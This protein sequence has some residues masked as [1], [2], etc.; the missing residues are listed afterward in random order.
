MTTEE[1]ILQELQKLTQKVKELESEIAI[2]KTG[3]QI[4]EPS[5]EEN[6]W[7]RPKYEDV[8]PYITLGGFNPSVPKP[9]E[10]DKNLWRSQ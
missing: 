1:L 9:I 4:K 5:Y 7:K 2:L 10:S 3:K 6:P 8:D